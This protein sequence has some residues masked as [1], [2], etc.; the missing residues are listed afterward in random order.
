LKSNLYALTLGAD[1]PD[2][3]EGPLTF[4]SC[5]VGRGCEKSIVIAELS[6]KQGVFFD[7]I[8]H[9]MFVIDAS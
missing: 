6:E 1:M 2:R 3:Y 4:A 9:T 5:C 8:D 7:L